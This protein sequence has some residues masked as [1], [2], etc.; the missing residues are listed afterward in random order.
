MTRFIL[1]LACLLVGCIQP[2]D[3]H[4]EDADAEVAGVLAEGR[5]AEA[6]A[7]DLK[8]PRQGTAPIDSRFSTDE[9]QLLTLSEALAVAVQRN[10]RYVT[11]KETLYREGLSLTRTRFNFGPQLSSTLS[12]VWSDD[13]FGEGQQRAGASGSVSQ[14]LPTGGTATLTGSLGATYPEGR[15]GQSF[16]SS[17]SLSVDQP[18]LRG[19]GY[20]VSHERLTQAERDLLY[21]VRDFELFRQDFSISLAQSYYDLVRQQQTLD[22]QA[23]TYLEAVY[24]RRKAEALRQV[25]RNTDEQV[26]RARRREV[27]TQAGLLDARARYRRALDEFKIVLGLPT[28]ANLDVV[29]ADPPYKAVRLNAASAVEAAR[30]NRL[31]VTTARQR[32]EDAERRAFLAE[33]GLLPQLDL[34][35]TGSFGGQDARLQKSWADEWSISGGLSLQLPLQLKRERNAY[36]TTVILR[37]RARR[38]FELLLDRVGL[39]VRDQLRQLSSVEQQI[40]I[41]EAQITQ[42]RRAVAVTEIRYEAGLLDNRDLLE[43]RQGLIDA[44][45]ALIRL[46]VDHFIR[47]LRLLRALGLLEIDAR[48]SWK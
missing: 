25:D 30:H 32:M 38:D 41:Q 34:N 3:W 6:A 36:K 14:I 5:A 29:K 24:D 8:R 23:R 7:Q 16:D 1:T 28:S 42:E 22:N 4:E 45:N 48:G 9:T 43:A 44:Q 2:S 35:V 27:V 13:E 21:A 17:V 12:Y 47:R 18:L 40:E 10:R 37:G 33:N 20:M 11:Q 39:E 19:V 31:D 26:F 15:T 46:K